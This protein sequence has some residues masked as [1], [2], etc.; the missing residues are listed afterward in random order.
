[1]HIRLLALCLL[2][3][4]LAAIV[5]TRASSSAGKD[6]VWK[7]CWGTADPEATCAKAE[8]IGFNAVIAW[9][10][11][12][13]YLRKLVKAGREHGLEV[14]CC[15]DFS[16]SKSFPEAFKQVMNPQQQRELAMLK[17]KS[18]SELCKM[19][20]QWGGD[21]VRRGEVS[22]VDMLCFDRPEV[23]GRIRASVKDVMQNVPG[24]TGLGVDVL[25]YQ[26]YRCCY[27]DHSEELFQTYLK[28][29]GNM[30]VEKARDQFSLER[31]I[32]TYNDLAEYARSFRPDVKT[33]CHV[34]PV[35][36][37]EALYGNRLDM[38]YCGETAAWFFKPMWSYSK[39]RS[40][41]QKIT[42]RQ[43]TRYSTQKAVA[44]VGILSAE[45]CRREGYNCIKS[46]ERIKAELRSIREAGCDKVMLG[47]F[48]ILHDTDLDE[49]LKEVF[50]GTREVQE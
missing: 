1:M 8:E 12:V 24:I 27:C 34:Y 5:P 7:A 33:T 14:Y 30:P 28:Q 45:R 38:D 2:A 32:W 18:I 21:P 10:M 35:F 25:G 16:Y 44:M 4:T 29:H 19:R 39:I 11:D 20:Y 46:P 23:M 6:F 49:C 26:N 47:C 40:Y 9:S 15:V 3:I 48:D 50:R 41:A 13:E 17:G 43:S 22:D 37:P 36:L 31:L 42:K